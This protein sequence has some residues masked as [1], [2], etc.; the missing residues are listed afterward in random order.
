MN[1]VARIFIPALQAADTS[2]GAIPNGMGAGIEPH[3]KMVNRSFECVR[4]LM[5]HFTQEQSSTGV[6]SGHRV[7]Y[8]I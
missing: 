8:A 7:P 6:D 4:S 1:R 2:G 3:T 5:R